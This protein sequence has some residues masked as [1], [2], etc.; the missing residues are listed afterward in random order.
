MRKVKKSVLR[1][2]LTNYLAK[3]ASAPI[4]KRTA[5][6][7]CQAVAPFGYCGGKYQSFRSVSPATCPPARFIDPINSAYAA[8]SDSHAAATELVTRLFAYFTGNTGY[9]YKRKFPAASCNRECILR[10][11]LFTTLHFQN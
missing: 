5:A 7:S 6:S 9:A 2:F 8:M 11:T 3:F 10:V 1:G 4:S